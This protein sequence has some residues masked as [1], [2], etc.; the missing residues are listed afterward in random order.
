MSGDGA[1]VVEY[2]STDLSGNVEEKK[3]VSFRI[4]PDAAP[5][6]RGPAPTPGRCRSWSADATFALGRVARTAKR[7]RSPAAD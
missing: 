7:G 5:P 1:H 3:T 4:G 6:A 2:R